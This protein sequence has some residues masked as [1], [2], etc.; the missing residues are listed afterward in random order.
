VVGICRGCQLINVA[1]GGT[2]YHDIPTQAPSSVR[3]LHLQQYDQQFHEMAIVPGTHLSALYPG[4]HT[5]T[6]N[7]IHHQA[8]KDLGRDLTVEARAQPDGLVEAIRWN[9]PSYVFGMQ[10]HPEFMAQQVSH[11]TQLDG[12]PVLSDFLSACLRRRG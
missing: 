1:L 12:S 11:A 5:A 4:V 3:H 6:I 8:V 7:S 10:W 9:G 2:L